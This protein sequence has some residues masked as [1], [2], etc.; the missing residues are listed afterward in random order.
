MTR[1]KIKCNKKVVY[2][3]ITAI[4]QVFE[5]KEIH[6]SSNPITKEV[7]LFIKAELKVV[8]IK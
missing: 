1:I 4:K 7:S 6:R 5:I 8:P 3:H 2:D